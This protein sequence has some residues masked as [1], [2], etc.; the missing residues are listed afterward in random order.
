MTAVMPAQRP[1]HDCIVIGYY[2]S[3]F[4]K[5]EGLLRKYGEASEAY[6]DLR[7][8]FVDIDGRK[9]TFPDLLN[10]V[11]R[12][13]RPDRIFER[14][15]ELKSGEI[16]NLAAVYLTQFLAKRG[17]HCDYINLF[18]YEKDRLAEFLSRDPIAI[19]ITTT[20]YVVN[21]PVIEIVKFV[22]E[23]NKK[24][25]IIVGGPLIANHARNFETETFRTAVEDMGADIYVIEGAGE[26]TLSQVVQCLK[27]GGDLAEVPNIAYSDNG[28]FVVTPRLL[29]QNSLDENYIDWSQFDAAALGP[30]IQTRTAR[31]CAFNCSFCN[32]PT[33]AGKLTLADI[34]TVERELD[35]MRDLGGVSNVVFIDDTFNVPLPRFK[36]LCRMMIR[37]KYN[38]NWFSYFRCSNSDEEALDL[39][40]ESGCRGVFLGIESGSPQIL[41]NMNK[42][43]TIDKYR[44]GIRMLR[45]RNIMTFGSFIVGFPGETEQ[46]IA[47]TESFIRETRVDYYRAQSWYC[48]SG[49][50]IDRQREKYGIKGEGFGWSHSTMNSTEAMAHIEK[51][52]LSIKESL[53]LPQWSYDFWFV[54]YLLGRGIGLEQFREFMVFG[55]KLLALE[56]G[57][58]PQRQKAL[59][60]R[61]Y[62]KKMREVARDWT[63]IGDHNPQAR[64]ELSN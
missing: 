39:M 14:E 43:A 40:A 42:A 57:N 19:A 22:R 36:D 61:Q 35:S 23:H 16:P 17:L 8:S 24:V 9:M 5:Y 53:W 13:S 31:S 63:L 7:F 27:D 44:D 52:F 20:L 11:I 2:E 3:P 33:R 12:Q 34:Q 15:T 49:T 54:P 29:E 41:T 6:R 58:V 21:M 26:L 4:D 32:Y 18:E 59:L 45:E 47:E 48:E 46:T 25:R 51:L 64:A 55:N 60:Q 1:S 30:T 56:I 28:K 10:E 38:F 37:N 50:P 62:M